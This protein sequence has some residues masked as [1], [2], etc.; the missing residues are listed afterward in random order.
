LKKIVELFESTLLKRTSRGSSKK[1]NLMDTWLSVGKPIFMGQV[2][3][4]VAAGDP[5]LF[6]LPAFPFKSANRVAKVLGTMPDMGEKLALDT[7]HQFLSEVEKHYKPG[8]R[9]VIFSD[10]RVY[11]DL[12]GISDETTLAYRIAVAKLNS[13]PFISWSDLDQFLPSDV[14]GASRDLLLALFGDSLETI[15]ERIKNDPDF[16]EVYCG[17][18]RL[19]NEDKLKDDGAPLDV[20]KKYLAEVAK[21]L[22]QRNAAYSKL[23]KALLQSHI[24]LSIH[25]SRNSSKFSINLVGQT[26]WGTPWHNCALLKANGTWSLIP[27]KEV[28]NQGHVLVPGDL[29]YYREK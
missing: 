10:G 17:F 15:Q 23:V 16:C 13:S 12:F 21:K 4:F 25:P 28:E 22:M 20:H 1:E 24:R 3:R 11:C 29:P 6:V 9:L 27:R 14:P 18:K 2:K 19:M 26:D 8:G 5:I 7:L